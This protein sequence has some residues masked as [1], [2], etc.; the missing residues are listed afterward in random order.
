MT[1]LGTNLRTK[2]Q[3]PGPFKI[4]IGRPFSDYAYFNALQTFKKVAYAMHIENLGNAISN[5]KL[6]SVTTSVIG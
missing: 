3:A 1:F 6:V 5:C 4:A 2:N